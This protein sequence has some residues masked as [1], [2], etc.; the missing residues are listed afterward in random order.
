ML[1]TLSVVNGGSDAVLDF[2]GVLLNTL[3]LPEKTVSKISDAVSGIDIGDISD[4]LQDL[5]PENIDQE[6]VSKSLYMISYIAMYISAATLVP[7]LGWA[8]SNITK[9]LSESSKIIGKP[10]AQITKIAEKGLSK[11][12]QT[13][14]FQKLNKLVGEGSKIKEMSNKAINNIK[15]GADTL[16]KGHNKVEDAIR[17]NTAKLLNKEVKKKADGVGVLNTTDITAGR[18]SRYQGDTNKL[19]G[20]VDHNINKAA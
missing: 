5:I 7:G 9:V 17:T 16:V 20:I 15:G 2:S 19:Q 13:D 3:F 11:I 1:D 4:G 8:S 12:T 18:I 10:I 14:K 6:L